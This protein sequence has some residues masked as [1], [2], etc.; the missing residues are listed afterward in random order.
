M[1]MPGHASSTLPRRCLRCDYD[2]HGLPD[3]GRCPECG[4]A[5]YRDVLVIDGWRTGSSHVEVIVIFIVLAFLGGQISPILGGVLLV[6]SVI[7]G[8]NAWRSAARGD[9]GSDQLIVRSDTISLRRGR[10]R[11][12]P[13]P[14][15]SYGRFKLSAT[16]VGV[17][18]HRH[19]E[20][21]WRLQV[22]VPVLSFQLGAKDIDFSFRAPTDVI[23]ALRARLTEQI[24]RRHDPLRQ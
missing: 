23:E 6:L 14:M 21:T 10:A 19:G 18:L 11:E 7:A 9:R 5:F 17:L 2:L 8:L 15:S 1:T 12:R 3:E 22:R 20:R 16:F 4:A 13:H 24:T